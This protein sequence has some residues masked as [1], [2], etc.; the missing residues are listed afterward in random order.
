MSIFMILVILH[1]STSSQICRYSFVTPLIEDKIVNSNIVTSSGSS[2]SPHTN[3]HFIVV[4][5]ESFSNESS[6][7]LAMIQ[8]VI[9][10]ASLLMLFR[11]Y[12]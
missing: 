2:E 5:T 8:H 3:Y 6:E 4:P 7:S 9:S 10:R 1:S 12:L 11:V